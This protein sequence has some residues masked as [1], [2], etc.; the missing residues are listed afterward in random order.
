MRKPV[1]P[2]QRHSNLLKRFDKI[3]LDHFGGKV[4][5]GIGWYTFHLG[6]AESVETANLI[7][8][9]FCV[10]D[11]R[12]IKVNKVLDDTRVPLWYLDFVVFHEMLHLQ[13]GPQQ[14]SETGYAYPHDLRF[15]CIEVS[16]PFYQRAL[17]FE[18]KKLGRIVQS[19]RKWREWA[20]W[21]KGE[22]RKKAAKRR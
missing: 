11:E 10:W 15:Q 8:Q 19:W 20:K 21:S 18:T 4:C 14:Y 7:T 13:R 22:R 1:Q 3:N 12:L 5:G 16:H 9:A 6:K 17:E 2:K